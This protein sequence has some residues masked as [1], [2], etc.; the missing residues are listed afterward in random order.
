ME[1]PSNDTPATV[2]RSLDKN[3]GPAKLAFLG[4]LVSF[5]LASFAF[6]VDHFRYIHSYFVVTGFLTTIG[7]GALFFVLLHHL[8]KARW[9]IF[10]C[11]QMQWIVSLLPRCAILFLP[12]LLWARDIFP[13][14]AADAAPKLTESDHV[15]YLHAPWFFVRAVAYWAIWIW[16]SWGYTTQKANLEGSPEGERLQQRR[17]RFSGPAMVLFALTT[18][19]AG[20]DWFMSLQPNWHSAIFGVYVFA[21]AVPSSLAVLALLTVLLERQGIIRGDH[22]VA[23][24]HDIAKLLFGFIVF[25]AYIAFS[26]YLLIWYAGIPSETSFFS[27]RFDHD[28]HSLTLWLFALHFVVPCA[29]LLSATAKRSSIVLFAVSLVVLAAHAVDIFWLVMPALESGHSRVGFADLAAAVLPVSTL[30]LLLSKAAKSESQLPQTSS[31]K[32]NY[33]PIA[34]L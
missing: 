27:L 21:G 6:R 15:G 12:N 25:W 8:V 23:T 11:R 3:S 1:L 9:S 20:F 7:L 26:Q 13:W 5:V 4:W 34:S 24:R 18:S 2:W 14:M 19:F 29:A 22:N 17:R 33:E 28:W 16:L 10:A 32:S 30:L 31:R